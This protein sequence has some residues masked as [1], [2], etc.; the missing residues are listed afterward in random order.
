MKKLMSAIL[1]CALTLSLAAGA[2][3]EQKEQV[4]VYEQNKLVKSVVFAVGQKEYFVDGKTPGVKMDVAPYISQNRT[5]VPVRY[6]GN[7]LGVTDENISWDTKTSKAKLTL[8]SRSAELTIGK[9]QIIS[10]GKVVEADVAPE[11]K[12][13]RTYL[14]ARFVAEALGYRV[15]FIDGLV[16]CY[17]E[18][19]QKPDISAV[20][21]Y[22]NQQQPPVQ[23]GETYNLN[24]YTVPKKPKTDLKI[25]YGDAEKVNKVELNIAIIV[26]YRDVQKQCDEAEQ[27]LA[28]KFGQAFAKQL[29]DLAR[30]KTDPEQEIYKDFTGPNGESIEVSS[31]WGA[32]RTSIVVWSPKGG[33]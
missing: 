13:G 31:P 18:G 20:K 32:T 27:I 30:Q 11:L 16:V 33:R 26:P 3:A 8:G 14:P 21:Q 9:K 1:T 15:D 24:G 12:S 17:P 7:A 25:V 28:S 4:N 10:N 29:V 2:M 23:Q 19:S 22:I 5:F 6:L